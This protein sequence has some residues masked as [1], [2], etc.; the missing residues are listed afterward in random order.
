MRIATRL[1]ALRL[2]FVRSIDWSLMRVYAP[3]GLLDFVLV[4]PDRVE[5]GRLAS[6]YQSQPF[7]VGFGSER[8]PIAC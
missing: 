7:H 8:S 6:P 2:W 5:Y 3:L 1:R 4:R